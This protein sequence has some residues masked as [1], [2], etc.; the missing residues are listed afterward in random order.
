MCGA[1]RAHPSPTP[2]CRTEAEAFCLLPYSFLCYLNSYAYGFSLYHVCKWGQVTLRSGAVFK[3]A[4]VLSF[5]PAIVRVSGIKYICSI[6]CLFLGVRR[7]LWEVLG[8]SKQS[9][10]SIRDHCGPTN[11]LPSESWARSYRIKMRLER[12]LQKARMPRLNEKLTLVMTFACVWI[13]W[14]WGRTCR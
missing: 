13:V 6:V 14:G 11:C 8:F 12:W 9:E 1:P 4:S 5:T 3:R 7:E 2:Q 10:L